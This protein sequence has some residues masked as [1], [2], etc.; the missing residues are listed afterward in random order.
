[1]R[2]LAARAQMQL[3]LVEWK[4]GVLMSAISMISGEIWNTVAYQSSSRA[5]VEKGIPSLVPSCCAFRF[6]QGK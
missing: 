6:H 4:H 5:G 3:S 1:M 2:F